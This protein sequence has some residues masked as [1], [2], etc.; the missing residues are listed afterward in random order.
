[1]TSGRRWDDDGCL[2]TIALM[3]RLRLA[4]WCG[5][6]PSRLAA[7][8]ARAR[9][10]GPAASRPT[11]QIFAKA[12]VAGAV[13]TRLASAVGSAR[14][15]AIHVQLA[16]RTLRT[17][18]AA[19][20]AGVV[21]R[22]ELWCAPDACHPSFAE[23][24][25]RYGVTL[26][27]QA[28]ADLGARMQRAL[29]TSLAQGSPALLVGTDCPTLDVEHLARAA[30]ALAGHDAVF[31]PAED[32]GYVLVGLA[33]NVD[34]FRDIAWGTPEV[35]AATRSRLR[36]GNAIWFELPPLWDVDVPADL[37]RWQGRNARAGAS[38]AD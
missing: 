17:A 15:A 1:V 38:A 4:Y 10:P 33:R 30:A 19:R 27:A 13:K 24:R 5:A 34:A 23:W 36:A 14:A 32:G 20:N 31:A 25:D 12:P 35:M 37:E 6:D 29:E 18:V 11:L 22:V 21:G 9:T 28:G 16:R 7:R 26:H 2:R 3:W 8:Y